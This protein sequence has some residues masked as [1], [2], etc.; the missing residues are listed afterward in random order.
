M[1]L[2]IGFTV[3]YE[4]KT[5]DFKALNLFSN[6]ATVYKLKFLTLNKTKLGKCD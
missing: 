6:E 5:V 1:V 2:F 4:L 3:H